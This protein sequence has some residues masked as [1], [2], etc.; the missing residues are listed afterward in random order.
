MHLEQRAKKREFKKALR[1]VKE[2]SRKC[3]ATKCKKKSDILMNNKIGHMLP[4]DQV[5]EIL[6]N[7][8]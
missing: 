1:L 6:K 8:T 7:I 4:K 3:S 2:E 5:D